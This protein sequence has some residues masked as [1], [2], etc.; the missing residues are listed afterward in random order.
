[1]RF[2][3][4]GARY[5]ALSV[6]VS[7]KVSRPLELRLAH[8]TVALIA[9]LRFRPLPQHFCCNLRIG[10]QLARINGYLCLMRVVAAHARK[11]GTLVFAPPPRDMFINLR[12][13]GL[14]GCIY[15]A[16]FH[17]CG[18]LNLCGVAFSNVRLTGT[19]AGFA[20]SDLILPGSCR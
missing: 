9:G 16:C 18:V 2:V 19:V 4:V 1:M 10:K 12:V 3:T 17:L 11:T 20:T 8:L 5:S 6:F 13:A 7:E 15:L 14:A